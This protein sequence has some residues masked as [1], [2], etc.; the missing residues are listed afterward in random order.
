[1]QPQITQINSDDFYLRFFFLSSL[2]IFRKANSF[3][4]EISCLLVA[5]NYYDKNSFRNQ[6]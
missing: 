1:M 3:F 4:R 5:Q 6:S 2:M